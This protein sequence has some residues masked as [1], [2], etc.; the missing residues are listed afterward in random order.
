MIALAVA[1]I[2][3]VANVVVDVMWCIVWSY[4]REQQARE[5]ETMTTV[6]WIQM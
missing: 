6:H 3:V 2:D 5:R 1:V 4:S